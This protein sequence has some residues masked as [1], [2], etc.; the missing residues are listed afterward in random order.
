MVEEIVFRV[1]LDPSDLERLMGVGPGVVAGA[2]KGAGGGVVP[3]QGQ[4]L[5][6]QPGGE[7]VKVKQDPSFKSIFKPLAALT[8]MEKT[9][10]GIL[11]HSSIANSYL[12]AMGKMFGAAIDMLLMPLT[13]IFNL[14]MVAMGKLLQWL[15]T[16]GILEKL[17]VVFT[18]VSENI[19]AM[20]MWAQEIWR[21]IKEFD[22]GKAMELG[23]KGVKGVMKEIATEPLAA[24]ATAATIAV[25]GKMAMGMAGKVLSAV[26][27]GGAGQAAVKAASTVGT[28]GGARL[29]GRGAGPFAAGLGAMQLGNWAGD[30]ITGRMP[31]GGEGERGWGTELVGKIPGGEGFMEK[32]VGMTG[33]FIFGGKHDEM[34]REEA[35]KGLSGGQGSPSGAA[36]QNVGNT[37]SVMINIDAE[38]LDEEEVATQ[39]KDTMEQL[40]RDQGYTISG[41]AA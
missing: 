28:A 2:G 15:V 6:E 16:S 38:G 25:G 24:I 8:V 27:L 17:Y 4:V 5:P 34:K 33:G 14:L 29:L 36:L 21:A 40:L 18:K 20:V 35:M 3:A 13:P 12:G 1:V 23:F 31:G 39:I 9:L 19:K 10:G 7:G 26:G 30:T 11:K 22:V 32:V 41:R 37:M